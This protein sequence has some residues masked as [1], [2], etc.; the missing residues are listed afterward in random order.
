MDK[1]VGDA[2][3]VD[4]I[5]DSSTNRVED[6]ILEKKVCENLKAWLVWNELAEGFISLLQQKYST[7]TVTSV[8]CMF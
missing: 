8:A 6:D 4:A 7:Y 3:T 2:N 1:R 5:A